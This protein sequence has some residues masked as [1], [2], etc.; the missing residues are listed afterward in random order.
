MPTNGNAGA[1]WATY[2]ARAGHAGARRDAGRRPDDH[3]PRVRRRRR[4][5]AP[6][7]RP[8]RRRRP[9]DRRGAVAERRRLFDVSTLKEPYRL[10]G[11]KTMGY[12]IVEQLGW[13]VPDVIVY[14]T[15]GGVGLIGIHKALRRDARARLDRPDRC[16]GW[17]PC[18]RPAARRSCGRS[19]AGA[20]TG[21]AVGRRAHR[22]VRHHRARAARRRA[23]PRRARA[24]PAAR[25]VAVDDGEMLADLRDV[26]RAARGCCCARRAAA[27]C[28]RGPAAA[29]R[30]LDRPATSEVVRAQH[31]CRAQVPRDRRRGPAGPRPRREH[32]A[33]D[34]DRA[35]RGKTPARAN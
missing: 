6:R 30:R 1:A 17:S 24:T 9:A 11:K 7:R 12:E 33:L 16:P 3:P 23:D 21:R 22:R 5:A 35:A 4:R 10:E 13:R 20:R 8:D 28:R 26:R 29:R 2:A 27:A 34:A 32:P 18:S 14:P 15:G 25:A 31:R 19:S